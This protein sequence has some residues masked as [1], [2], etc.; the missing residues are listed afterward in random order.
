[1]DSRRMLPFFMSVTILVIIAFQVY[2]VR[3][4]YEREKRTMQIKAGVAFTETI[5]QLQSFNLKLPDS[6]LPGENHMRPK[7]II[8]NRDLRSATGEGRSEVVTM[9][10]VLRNNLKD[11]SKNFRLRTSEQP[12]R[13]NI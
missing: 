6:L 9:V 2:W 12:N 4:N 5:R 7:R 11:T 3:D 10:D 13:F 8:I 1:M